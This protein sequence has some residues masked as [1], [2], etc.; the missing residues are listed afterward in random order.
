M[1]TTVYFATDHAGFELKELLLAYVRDELG[2]AVVDCGAEVF[3]PLDDF[4]TF[5]PRAAASVAAEP[6]T[7]RAIILGGSGQGEAMAANRFSGVRTAVYYGGNESIVPFSREHNDANVLSI[8][9]RFVS[10]AEAKQVVSLWLS[11]ATLSDA[12]YHRRN[13]A[14]DGLPF[15]NSIIPAIIPTSAAD[16]IE[17]IHKVPM[18]T[19]VQIDVVDGQFVPFSSWPYEPHGDVA[20]LAPHLTTVRN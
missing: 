17:H 14:L 9:A 1:P 7:R 19:L 5:I 18:G 8:G 12:K 11:T 2:Y 4:T 16:V 20:E 13:E 15:G 3:D 6:S 10:V